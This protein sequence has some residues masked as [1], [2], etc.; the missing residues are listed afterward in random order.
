[1]RP[2]CPARPV[3]RAPSPLDTPLNTNTSPL[4]RPYL[5]A[6]EAQ[7]AER[8]AHRFARI[9]TMHGEFAV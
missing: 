7:Y 4:V 2:T 5:T 1:M 6:Y 9:R 8:Q 3:R